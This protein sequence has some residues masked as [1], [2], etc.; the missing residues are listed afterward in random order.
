MARVTFYELL[1]IGYV[2]YQHKISDHQQSWEYEDGTWKGLRP[3]LLVVA[4][5]YSAGDRATAEHAV[6]PD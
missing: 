6:V 3:P 2:I 4:D 1:R 5:F